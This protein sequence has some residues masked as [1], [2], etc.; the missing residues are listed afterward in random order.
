MR[1]EY[2]ILWIDDEEDRIAGYRENIAAYLN[3][4]GFD[5]KTTVIPSVSNEAIEKI[6]HN[7]AGFNPYNLIL[8]DHHFPDEQ[9]GVSFAK[10]L[11]DTVY[12]DMVYYSD[13]SIEEL[14]ATLYREKVDGVHISNRQSLHD[15]VRAIIE[16]QIKRDFDAVNM[17]G[18]LLDALSQMEGLLRNKHA[19]Y[20]LSLTDE[21]REQKIHDMMGAIK[22]KQEKLL[23]RVEKFHQ[24]GDVH[25]MLGCTALVTLD[26]V[27][28]ALKGLTEE[29]ERILGQESEFCGLQQDRNR[30]AHDSISLDAS[31]QRVVL[32]N[33]KSHSEGY[34]REDF[35]K[36]R[37]KLAKV[38]AGL[39]AYIEGVIFNA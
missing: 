16:D 35:E 24:A 22:S 2:H 13:A 15:D 17:R 30:W 10:R 36:M 39:E 20:F 29:G 18:F 12:T 38:G 9:L 21:V 23:R 11:R 27:R 1:H 31:G 14:R 3:S 6:E 34:S 8:V 5:L 28:D 26:V 37:V 4:V 32:A 25:K 33:D 19:E 7:L